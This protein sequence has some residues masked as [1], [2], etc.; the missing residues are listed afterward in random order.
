M[1]SI[2]SSRHTAILQAPRPSGSTRKAYGDAQAKFIQATRDKINTDADFFKGKDWRRIMPTGGTNSTLS[3]IKEC[4]LYVESFYVKDLAVWV[5]HLIVP[6]FRPTCPNCATK[7]YIDI[8]TRDYDWIERP[9]ILYGITKHRYLDT[10]YYSCKNCGGKFAG[11]N[12]EC[13]L[14][15]GAELIGIFNYRLG[16]GYA[17]DDELY[18]FIISH[19]NETTAS[20][21]KRLTDLATDKWIDDGMFYYKAVSLR[22]VSNNKMPLAAVASTGD[23]KQQGTIDGYFTKPVVPESVLQRKHRNTK[24]HLKSAERYLADRKAK[25]EGDVEFVSVFKL[26]ENRNEIDLPF[27]GIGK[28]KLLVLIEAGVT[29]AKELLSYSGN[30]PAVL[31]QWRVIVQRYY[32]ELESGIKGLQEAVDKLRGELEWIELHQIMEA[33]E[34]A[35]R[36]ILAGDNSRA[37]DDHVR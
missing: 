36:A 16:N 22:K 20:I 3:H 17:I 7:A 25:L 33:E 1:T 35:D 34:Q 27:K 5:P 11:Y 26:K 12:E 9:K 15:D 8:K 30:N 24:G 23:A 28:K 21:Y 29:S 10:I 13:M 14:K 32:D 37:I 19:S 6:G 4:S 31:P 18:S 2:A